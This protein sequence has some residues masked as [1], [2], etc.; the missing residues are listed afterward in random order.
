MG[1]KGKTEGLRVEKTGSGPEKS[2]KVKF[3]SKNVIISTSLSHPVSLF[4]GSKPADFIIR[5]SPA[6]FFYPFKSD[7]AGGQASALLSLVFSL[8]MGHIPATDSMPDL[9]GRLIDGGR[10]LLL[11]T[12]GSGAYG[13]VYRALDKS[14]PQDGRQFYAVKCLY[15]PEAGSHQAEFQSREFVNHKVVC[16]HPNIVTLHRVVFDKHYVYVVLDL[17]SGGDL[18]A[19]ITEKGLYHNN[20]NLVKKTFV[21]IIDAVEFCHDRGVFH[22]DIKPENVLCSEDGTHIWLADFGLS[23][24]NQ[25]SRDLGCG[26]SYYMSPGNSSLNH[27]PPIYT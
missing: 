13:R 16:E 22:R 19:A 14:S 17:C 18:F 5:Y 25:V 3:R 6:S 9:Q 11:D 4:P 8:N 2:F 7:F 23:T 12:L 1:L 10:M 27:M 21:Q 26:S 15:K 20:V 24:R